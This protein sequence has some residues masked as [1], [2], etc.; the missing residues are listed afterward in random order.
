MKSEAKLIAQMNLPAFSGVRVMMMP[1]HLH[2]AAGTLPELGGWRS[3]VSK[4][5]DIAGAKGVGYLTIDEALVKAGTTHRRPGIHVDGIGEDGGDAPYGGGGG[6]AKNG[7]YM[8][9]SHTGCRV[10]NQ[11]F[12]GTPLPNGDCSNIAHECGEAKLIKSNQLW[13]CSPTCVH[14]ALEMPEDTFRQFCR[15]SMPSTAPWHEGYTPSPF[16]VLPTGP[17]KP[18][19]TA[20]MNY[21]P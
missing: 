13:W 16:G 15:V 14:E 1:F 11:D 3:V 2:D 10:W 4:I 8:I 12:A 5:S 6:Y 20:F 18:P 21:R 9:S 17:I 19:R 7:M